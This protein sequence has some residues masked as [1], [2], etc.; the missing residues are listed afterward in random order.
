MSSPRVGRRGAKRN[1]RAACR[2][3]AHL[4]GSSRACR[5]L[6]GGFVPVATVPGARAVRLKI[7]KKTALLSAP[8]SPF[9]PPASACSTAPSMVHVGFVVAGAVLLR[10]RGRAR[11]ANECYDLELDPPGVVTPK[12][13]CSS[14]SLC[15]ED[16]AEAKQEE[17]AC[18][19]CD[20]T[21]ACRFCFA[22]PERGELITPCDC[23]G[24][25]VSAEAPEPTPSARPPP[26]HAR[27]YFFFPSVDFFQDSPRRPPRSTG[28]FLGLGLGE[29]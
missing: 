6:R 14:G 5:A 4:R 23:V 1:A 8:G 2:A 29:R 15:L 16:D 20:E 26:R 13:C 18:K 28:G 10:L 22:G 9:L 24:S 27:V 11:S 17:P 21:S 3:R 25:Q 7:A 19:F 12:R